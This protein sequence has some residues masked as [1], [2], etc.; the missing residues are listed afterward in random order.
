VV[1]VVV[2]RDQKL[3]EEEDILG[4]GLSPSPLEDLL[5]VISMGEQFRSMCASLGFQD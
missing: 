4:R 1:V 2:D 5:V 3:V